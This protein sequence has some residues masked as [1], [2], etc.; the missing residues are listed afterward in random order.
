MVLLGALKMLAVWSLRDGC[1]TL[2][3]D[4]KRAKRSLCVGESHGVEVIPQ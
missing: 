2:G 1:T 4:Y 3:A